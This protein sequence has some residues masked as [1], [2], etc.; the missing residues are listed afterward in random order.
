MFYFFLERLAWAAL[1]RSRISGSVAT[2]GSFSLG[3]LDL[4]ILYYILHVDLTTL[5]K[6]YSINNTA[7]NAATLFIFNDNLN[8]FPIYVFII[9]NRMGLRLLH[10]VEPLTRIFPSVEKPIRAIN[11]K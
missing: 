3:D 5:F 9:I 10:L 8:F 6:K 2:S 7:A 1:A 4:A 11:T